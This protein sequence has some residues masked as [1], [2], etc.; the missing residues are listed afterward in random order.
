M[1]P[2]RSWATHPDAT[3]R[4]AIAGYLGRGFDLEALSDTSAVVI[5]RKRFSAG[6]Y[7]LLGWLYVLGHLG[8]SDERRRLWVGPQGQLFD[9]RLSSNPANDPPFAEP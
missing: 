7:F 1:N 9:R 3:L 6:R 8:S 2:E 5:K 4:L